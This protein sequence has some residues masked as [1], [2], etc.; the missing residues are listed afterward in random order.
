MSFAPDESASDLW[1]ERSFFAGTILGAAS[2]G[3][4]PIYVGAIRL[5]ITD[6][7]N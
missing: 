3:N 5:L 6:T 7:R 1:L 4:V 2:Y